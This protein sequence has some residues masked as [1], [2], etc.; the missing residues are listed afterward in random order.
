VPAQDTL[1]INCPRCGYDLRGVVTSWIN[2][3][4]LHG[5]CSECG[6]HIPWRTLVGE[7]RYPLWSFEHAIAKPL[8]RFLQTVLRLAR[9]RAFWH[10]LAMWHEIRWARLIGFVFITIAVVHLSAAAIAGSIKAERVIRSNREEIARYSWLAKSSV[11]N[12]GAMRLFP[13]PPTS[14]YAGAPSAALGELWPYS[15][16]K[17]LGASAVVHPAVVYGLLVTLVMPAAFIALPQ[18]LRRAKVRRGHIVR[19]FLYS[20]VAFPFLLAVWSGSLWVV[21]GGWRSI[22]YEFLQTRFLQQ[23]EG[24]I[25]TFMCFLWLLAWWG[26]AVKYYLRLPRSWM[27]AFA[28]LTISGL[29][30]TVV[31]TLIPQLAG[32]WLA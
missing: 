31:M 15:M 3:C 18:T 23:H 8:R 21:V 12:S 30:G 11:A 19:V 17:G 22:P 26:T 9:P 4:P 7:R 29:V 13:P 2:S 16:R 32:L 25:L 27:I 28:M 14:W 6:L 24:T 5:N 10:E 1:V 20:L